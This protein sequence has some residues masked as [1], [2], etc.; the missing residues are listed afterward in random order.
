MTRT[1]CILLFVAQLFVSVVVN[2]QVVTAQVSAKQ[3][4]VGQPFEYAI[5]INT[6]PNSYA[7][8]SFG[9]LTVMGGPNQS[10]S[11]QQINGQAPTQQIT[12][13]WVL[14]GQKEGKYTIGV[15][16]VHAGANRYT[17]QAIAVEIG[18]GSNSQQGGAKGEQKANAP[19]GTDYFIRT[20][21]NKTSCYVGEQIT[22]TQKVFARN[23]IIGYSKKLP[24]SYDGFYCQ[25]VESPTQGQ[26]MS[27]N[28]DGVQFFTHEATR[29][30]ATA[31][32]AGK[33]SLGPIEGEIVVR[34][35]SNARPRTIWEQFMGVPVTED[36]QIPVRSKPVVIDVLPLPEA[37]KPASFN[38]AVGNFS[39]KV[40][41]TRKELKANEAF[42]LKM[43]ISGKG[44]IKLLDAPKLNLPES[45][46]AYEPKIAETANSKTFDFLIIPRHEGEFTI[47]SIDFSYFS[48]D[49]KKYVTLPSGE[50]KIKVLP[51]DAGSAGTQVYAPQTQVKETENDIRYIKKGEFELVKTET[52]FFNSGTHLALLLLPL[53]ALT[54]G[55]VVRRNHIRNNSNLV[56]VRERKAAKLA[57]KQLAN[58][59]KL[60]SQNKK[61]EFYTEIL[62]AINSYL[63]NK[64]NIPVADLSKE[65]V[66]QVLR[67]RNLTEEL[68]T[69]L[70]TTIENGE[71]AKYA[72]GALSG[73]LKSVYNDTVTLITGLEDHLNKNHK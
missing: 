6:N 8:P 64:L 34:R 66:N 40:D 65:T 3:V 63:S 43:T 36:V 42:N 17:T 69:K 9:G 30:L 12:L 61:D 41:V 28:I 37:G 10:I 55:I 15:A 50:I 21:T 70:N 54:A 19:S 22:I 16:E 13:S 24:V 35:Q 62:A 32:Q 44:N 53:L 59:E 2:A 71:Y 26:L 73:D 68:L 46:E 11:M 27:E 1:L 18:K 49:T 67:Q 25:Q 14:V 56:L 58:A 72:P 48:L 39:S 52:E 57:R 38:G 60:M 31:N 47:E 7:P 33:I 51:P 29:I 23:A 4:P 5:T 20:S 45:F